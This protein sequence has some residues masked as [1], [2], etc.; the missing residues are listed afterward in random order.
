MGVWKGLCFFSN[1]DK[2][3]VPQPFYR[4]SLGC[5]SVEF[6]NE[7]ESDGC[8]LIAEHLNRTAVHPT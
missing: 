8:R 7:N 6:V 3:S 2:K 5:E 4:L 1:P